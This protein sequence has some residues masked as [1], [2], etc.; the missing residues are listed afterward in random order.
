MSVHFDAE[1]SRARCNYRVYTGPGYNSLGETDQIAGAH[2]A[3]CSDIFR[4]M[5]DI[6]FDSSLTKCLWRHFLL[7]PLHLVQWPNLCAAP[8][9]HPEPL[10]TH[11][12]SS[13]PSLFL[14]PSSTGT[15]LPSLPYPHHH[16]SLHECTRHWT[17][18]PRVVRVAFI[19]PFEPDVTHGNL[20]R[21]IRR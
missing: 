5:H 20:Q 4:S 1:C 17:V 12:Q 18:V 15:R 2:G 7:H 3:S 10:A 9:I 6:R 11:R 21:Y 19:V 16:S 8:V 13:Q 14:T